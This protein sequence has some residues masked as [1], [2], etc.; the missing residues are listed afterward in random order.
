MNR[1]K[2]IV[3]L[4]LLGAPCSFA[5][6]FVPSAD[7]YVVPANANNFGST[8]TITVGSA[9][10]FGLLQ[11]DLSQLPAGVTAGQI[12]KATL[13]LFLNHVN[14]GGTINI[15]T[16]STSTP[17]SE[18][19]VTGNT[20]IGPQ[21]AVAT[22]VPAAISNVYISV[23]ATAAVQGWIS[24]STTN[25]GFLILANGSTSVQFD[26]KE[27]T[28]TG[29]SATLS[30]LLANTGATGPTGATGA[31]STVAGPTGATGSTGA[32]GA[33]GAASTVAG[34]TGSTGST[35]AT[36]A[37]GAASS[38]A[39]PTGPTGPVST[40]AGPTGPTGPSGTTGI[41]GSYAISGTAQ[42]NA[43]GAT[44]TV[45]QVILVAGVRYANNFLPAD[46]RTI[47][48][49]GNTALFSLVGTLYGGDGTTN[50]GLPDLRSAAPN[51]TM[52]V[53]C[54]SGTF[55]GQ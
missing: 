55:P 27:S 23:D 51:N 45:G 28:G 29:H 6:V 22:S 48:I 53:I 13:T 46:G 34:P 35:G 44:C 1:W 40:V 54:L 37:T 18:S 30:V 33:T 38:V 42:G 50:F 9:N 17:W 24:G 16:V 10:S 14:S 11:F 21:A 36:G 3:V 15:D 12:Q 31:A 52:Y 49:S 8:P 39:G 41:F 2:H 20:V 25:N 26:S 47:P 19:S 7:A 4:A 43:T 32:T 5:Q